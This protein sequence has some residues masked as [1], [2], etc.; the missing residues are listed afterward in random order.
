MKNK[1]K[2][3][4]SSPMLFQLILNKYSSY[5]LFTIDLFEVELINNY[6]KKSNFDCNCNL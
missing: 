5:R 1:A 2:Y 6:I 3:K 4:K